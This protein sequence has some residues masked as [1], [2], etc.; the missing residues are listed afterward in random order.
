M[1]YKKNYHC[2][3]KESV[4]TDIFP[5]G[6]IY[7]CCLINSNP[8]LKGGVVTDEKV[9]LD[10]ANEINFLKNHPFSTC[11]AHHYLLKSN[12]IQNRYPDIVPVC[13]YYKK[14]ILPIS[15]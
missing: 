15:A 10:D 7:H 9:I 1:N 11:P 13:V 5:D 6:N 2:L 3:I 4:R 8:K 12:N 14:V